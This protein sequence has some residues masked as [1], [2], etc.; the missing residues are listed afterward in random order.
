MRRSLILSE[1]TELGSRFHLVCNSLCAD[2]FRAE[3]PTEVN[4]R[5]MMRVDAVMF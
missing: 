5:F 2:V 4:N 1:R 3:W